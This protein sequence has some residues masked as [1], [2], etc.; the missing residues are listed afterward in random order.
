MN[1]GNRP[2][3]SEADESVPSR[4]WFSPRSVVVLCALVGILGAIL[5]TGHSNHVIAALPYLLLLACPLMHF[6]MQGRHSTHG[7]HKGTH[8]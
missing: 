4:G 7:N 8:Q 3:R 5:L 2:L 1:Y 6:F